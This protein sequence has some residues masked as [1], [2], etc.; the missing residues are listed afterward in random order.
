MKK[1]IITDQISMD[2]E[3]ALQVA[4]TYGYNLVEIHAVWGKT[5]EMLNE[6]EVFKI[7]QLLNKYEISVS[8]LGSTLFLVCPL[9]EKY[10]VNVIENYLTFNGSYIEHI[11]ALKK[12]ADISKT[13]NAPYIRVFPFRYPA[14]E[15]PKIGD[16]TS[17]ILI[18]KFANIV[19]LA[20]KYDIKLL[21]EN[22]PHSMGPIGIINKF[23]IDGVKSKYLNLLW[24]PGNSFNTSEEILSDKY[25]NILLKDELREILP[26]IRHIHLKDYYPRVHDGKTNL[27][28]VTFGSGIIEYRKLFSILIN[29]G[30]K[31]ALSLETEVNINDT[32]LSLKTFDNILNNEIF[33]NKNS[34]LNK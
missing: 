30:Y 4:R 29:N 12:V 16:E 14:N 19:D 13:L 27:E 3:Q 28:L 1:S 8:C 32:L 15:K 11:E 2:F 31:N 22:C 23:I 20:K 25:T 17:Q 9:L 6:S 10:E 34:K 5:I 26:F 33:Y 7:R 21:I 18:E 24:D